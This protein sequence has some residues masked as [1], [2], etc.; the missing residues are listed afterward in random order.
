M[1][2]LLHSKRF[3][4]NLFKWL[5]MYCGVLCMLTI[6]VTYSRYI[7]TYNGSDDARV[8]KFALDMT[9]SRICE[10]QGIGT[11][12]DI[13]STRPEEYLEYDFNIDATKGEVDTLIVANITIDENFE[14]VS[15][16]PVNGNNMEYTLLPNGI[17]FK[18]TMIKGTKNTYKIKLKY[19]KYYEDAYKTPIDYD[20]ILKVDYSATQDDN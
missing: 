4:K 3:K 5:M 8:A 1:N 9:Y 6:V 14:F 18:G 16:T 19:K 11:T 7:T 2:S 15:L 10:G 13:G 12:C 17:E 20:K